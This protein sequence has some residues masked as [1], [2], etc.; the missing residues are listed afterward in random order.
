MAEEPG[1][2]AA[3]GE[4]GPVREGGRQRGGTGLPGPGDLGVL[5]VVAEVG[6]T[7]VR[8]PVGDLQEQVPVGVGVPARLG[9]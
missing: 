1:G 8:R 3:D 7:R 4:F 5:G 6:G 2:A 9:V